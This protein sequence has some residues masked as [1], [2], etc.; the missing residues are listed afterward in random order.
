MPILHLNSVTYEVEAGKILMD[1]IPAALKPDSPCGG[2][3]KC[4]KCRIHAKGELSP[5]SA[6]EK[7]LLTQEEIDSGV[8]L[9]CMTRILGD[10]TAETIK[11]ETA[12]TN[13]RI[14]GIMPDFEKKPTYSKLGAVVD[15]GTT[16]V[17]ALLYRGTEP[18]ARAS[19]ENGQK[20]FGADVI[21][22]IG[23]SISGKGK[24]IAAAV[25]KNISDLI[26]NMTSQTGNSVD[27]VEQVVITGN[28]AMLFLLTE[29]DPTCLSAAPFIASDLFGREVP[30]S[31]L[32][33]PCP[34]ASVY[35]PSC[36][37]SF[38]GADITTAVLA[39][40]I[41]DANQVSLL[42]DIGTNGEM[43]LVSD[44]KLLCC[45]TAA[46][47][48]FEGAG[49]TMGMMGKPGAIDKVWVENGEIATHTIGDKAAAG[50]CGSGIIDA[51]ATAMDLEVLDE[52]GFLETEEEYGDDSCLKL[53]EPVVITQT[54]IRMVQLAKS[55]IHAGALTL[56]EESGLDCEKIDSFLI[57][58]G[59]GSFINT[60]NAAKIGLIPQELLG[61]TKVLG[62][63]ALSGA[64]MLLLNPELR[65]KATEIA[66]T[67]E[68]VDLSTNPT[69]M[70]LYVDSMMF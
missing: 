40:G 63:A 53:T 26:L 43:A 4:G 18:I 7:K 56:V 20:I 47:P 21:S 41:C 6:E 59:F 67:S 8:R 58:G 28:T 23:Q 15:L 55:A 25:R 62:N 61:K 66:E 48:A 49:I 22:R 12:Q 69:F 54:D 60:A 70:E 13:I 24:E 33:L 57:A 37:S 42:V 11:K 14:E 46:G 17:A 19:C 3:G 45:S 64:A 30:G 2:R 39:S 9:A 50:I 44:G 29:T 5:L 38:V 32:D 36:M 1:C 65:K 52:N 51:V 10:C 34:N 16:T 27:D 31:E 35:L 68:T